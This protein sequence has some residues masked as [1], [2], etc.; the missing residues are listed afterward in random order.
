MTPSAEKFEVEK[1]IPLPTHSK[2]SNSIYPFSTMQVG[3]SFSLS[4][5]RHALVSQAAFGWS[6]KNPGVKFSV[7]KHG[8]AYRCW[9]IK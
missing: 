7:R 1:G 2:L 4:I 9:R 8:G 3:D 6:K 5:E